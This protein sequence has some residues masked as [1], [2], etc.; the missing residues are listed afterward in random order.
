MKRLILI[1]LALAGC[2]HSNAQ[3]ICDATE[4]ARPRLAS[5]LVE[6]GGPKSLSEGRTLIAMIDAGCKA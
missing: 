6:D 4:E 5:A 2:V 3:A 1:P